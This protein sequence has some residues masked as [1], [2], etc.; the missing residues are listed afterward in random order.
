MQRNNLSLNVVLF[1]SLCIFT[2]V[3]G[4]FL[5]EDSTGGGKL[6]FIHEWKSLNQFKLGIFE[7]LTS[8]NYESS[9]TPLFLILNTFNPFTDN[10]YQFRFS[11]F[12]FNFSIPIAYFYC[13]RIKKVDQNLSLLIVCTLLLSPYFRTTSYW[14][15]QENLPIFFLLTSF[16]YFFYFQ[17]N[18]FNNNLKYFHIL[19]IAI[20][21][22]LSFYSDQKFIFCSLTI[23]LLLVSIEKNFYNKFK[24]LLLF[25]ITS[26][27]AFYLYY[28]WGGIVPVESQ[29]RIGFSPKNLSNGISIIC[30]Y[31]VPV[32]IYLILE[33]KTHLLRIDKRIDV[34]VLLLISIF[35]FITIPNFISPWGN[36]VIYKIFFLIN[37]SII[38]NSLLLKILYVFTITLFT[39]ITY[40][41]LKNNPINFFPILLV[42]I[43][44]S[45]VEVIYQEYFDPWITIM[46]FIFFTFPKE[47]NI[48][49]TKSLIIFIFYNALFLISAN[50]YYLKFNLVTN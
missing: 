47:I 41:L 31:F 34:F 4:F 44:S 27:P 2:F 26:L 11:N 35:I 17:A 32:L 36:G 46:I 39:F 37:K 28:L 25:F 33:K 13:L 24:I 8:I 16:G 49:K 6:D 18:Y 42:L 20:I 9:R 19:F 43:I 5:N 12:L 50:I 22:S 29:F 30:F 38:T 40:K 21:S 15:H 45:F 3:L 10:Q 7:S 1:I 48:Y 14:A 23:F